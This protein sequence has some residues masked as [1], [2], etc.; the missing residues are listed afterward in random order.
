MLMN[1]LIEVHKTST[2]I[3][4]VYLSIKNVFDSVISVLL[5]VLLSYGL[6]PWESV[7]ACGNDLI[8]ILLTDDNVYIHCIN[9]SISEVLP[10]LSEISQ[11]SILS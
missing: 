7:G 1:M 10:V 9:K 5:N 8:I 2:L 6:W 11:D 4:T 3:D